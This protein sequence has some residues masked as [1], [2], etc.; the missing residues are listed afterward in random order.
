MSTQASFFLL[1]SDI[2]TFP[3]QHLLIINKKEFTLYNYTHITYSILKF[4]QRLG[5]EHLQKTEQL[6]VSL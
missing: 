2:M 5:I 1:L 6:N 3:F 4:E